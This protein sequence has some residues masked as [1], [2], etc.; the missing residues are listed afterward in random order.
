M[1]NWTRVLTRPYVL[2]AA[3]VLVGGV[4]V[5]ALNRN[6]A[7]GGTLVYK[8]N[9]RPV[10]VGNSEGT[11]P[12]LKSLDEMFTNLATF[13]SEAVVHIAVRPDRAERYAGQVGGDG[14]GLILTQDGWIVTNDHVVRNSDTVNVILADGRE[15][16][17][18]VT[19]VGDE[20]LDLA[21]VKVDAANL[22]LLRF[23][24]S[25]EVKPGQMVL[26]VGSPFGLENTVTFGHVSAIGR[27][28]MASDGIS[29]PRNYSGMIQTDA[30]INP[31][32]SGGPLI[33]VDGHVI[34]INTSIYS[35]TGT[36]AGIGFA[37]PA[38]VVRAVVNEVIETGKFD[39]G[40]MG[41][42][43]RNLKPYEQKDLGISGAFVERISE[44]GPAQKVGIRAGDVVTKVDGRTIT[45]EIDLRVALYAKSPKDTVEVTY[46]RDGSTKSAKLTLVAPQVVTSV[47]PQPQPQSPQ[48]DEDPFRSFPDLRGMPQQRPTLGV[49]LYDVDETTR[50]QFD[51]PG[52]LDGALIYRVRTDSLAEKAGLKIG[53]VI[54]SINDK[55]IGGGE[56]V[57]GIMSNAKVGDELVIKYTRVEAGKALERNVRIRLR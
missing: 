30:S 32:N 24:D 36:S 46:V 51:L 27:I 10:S 41:I 5:F 39:R 3:L 13:A 19:H 38:N 7:N 18:K 15:L 43:P 1:N 6:G 14:S 35:S 56:D 50:E 21:L 11:A 4:T 8:P 17:G 52:G 16:K 23:A 55:K 28:G 44:G 31:G 54:T 29:T 53:D 25:D 33:N 26:A 37:I 20:Q 47:E 40:L 9:L 2:F 34:G 45:N 12:S 57:I 22:P 49:Y 48:M 42:E